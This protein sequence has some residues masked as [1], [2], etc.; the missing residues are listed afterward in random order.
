MKTLLLICLAIAL[1]SCK[2]DSPANVTPAAK[3]KEFNAT[4]TSLTTGEVITINATGDKT[5][6]GDYLFTGLDMYGENGTASVDIDAYN[7]DVPA[8]GTYTGFIFAY[9]RTGYVGYGSSYSAHPGSVTFTRKTSEYV[10]GTFETR[11]VIPN[12]DSVRIEGNF[13]GYLIY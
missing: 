7:M 10:E 11:C 5:R 12:V 1:Y 9:K 8:P 6:L 13:K 2:K 3:T 4:I